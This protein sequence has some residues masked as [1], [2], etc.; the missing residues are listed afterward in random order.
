MLWDPES[1]LSFVRVYKVVPIYVN[2]CID[3]ASIIELL[4]LLRTVLRHF[5][6]L[7]LIQPY[8]DTHAGWRHL[9][10]QAD[11]NECCEK[12][13]LAADKSLQT[14]KSL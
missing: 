6:A 1:F 9:G 12:E 13:T 7:M 4:L 10:R 11:I 2:V 8:R 3:C 5:L 14:A